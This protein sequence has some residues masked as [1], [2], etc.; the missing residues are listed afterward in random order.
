VTQIIAAPMVLVVH[1]SMP[2]KSV[3]D[4]IRV[5]KSKPGQLNYASAGIGNLQHLAMESLQSMAGVKM[6]HVPYK[7]AAPAFIDLVS[8]QV[9]LMFANIVGVLPHVD[10]GKVRAI[11]VSNAAGAPV[12]PNTPSVA[13]TLP[14]FDLDGWMGIFVRAGTSPDIISRL[15]KDLATAVS[16]EDFK[17]RFAKR[18]A[19]VAVGGPE[20]L[21]KI[22]RYETAL[23]G[24][25]IQSA[26]IRAQ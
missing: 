9:Q 22:V 14:D 13:A 24:K 17:E 1:P 3:R 8:G 18:G 7:G 25:I 26:G 5:A 23:Y 12:L 6:N 11:A 4:L 2:V 16:G 10:A 15:H 19:Q 21:A 20:G